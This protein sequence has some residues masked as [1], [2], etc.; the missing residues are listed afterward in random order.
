[1]GA[2]AA[3]LILCTT[4]D[5]CTTTTSCCATFSKVSGTANATVP[6]KVCIPTGTAING[7][8]TIT[9]QV[10][11]VWGT[12]VGAAGQA[13]ATAAC[14]VVAAGASTLAVSAVAAATAVYM[15]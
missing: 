7:A 2:T 15:M 6:P 4:T 9:A 13:F 11:I 8:L 5:T 3:D 14:P 10:G 1:M 12:A